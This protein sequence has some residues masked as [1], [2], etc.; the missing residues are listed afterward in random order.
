MSPV[1]PRQWSVT[2]VSALDGVLAVHRN[3]IALA[4][5]ASDPQLT[6]VELLL[7]AVGNCFAL[8]CQAAMAARQENRVP[9]EVRVT[10]TKAAELPSRLATIDVQIAFFGLLPAQQA[11]AIAAHAKRLC[12]VSNTLAVATSCNVATV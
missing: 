6:P 5:L 2:T 12:T 10:G 8:S 4:G 1:A 3:G 9:F 11:A 7:I